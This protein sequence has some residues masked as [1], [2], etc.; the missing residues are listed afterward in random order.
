MQE[1]HYNQPF[2]SHSQIL[3][4]YV[5]STT[6]AA[7]DKEKLQLGTMHIIL[8]IYLYKKVKSLYY[9]CLLLYDCTMYIL[10]G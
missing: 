8:I 3:S 6:P 1:Y 5:R 9:E 2:A 10:P 7:K 4:S